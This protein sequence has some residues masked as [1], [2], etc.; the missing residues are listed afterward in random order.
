MDATQKSY[1][2]PKFK[3]Q[4]NNFIGGEWVAPVDGEYF[5]NASPVDGK[6]FTKI[7]RSTEAD[8]ELALDAAHKAA[9][10]WN[11]SS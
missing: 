7:A 4:Y 10:E 1:D 2:I 3:E 11:N 8:V 5:E 9:P 6:V